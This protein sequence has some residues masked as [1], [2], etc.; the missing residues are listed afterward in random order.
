MGAM[1][2]PGGCY[3]SPQWGMGW[4]ARGPAVRI[5]QFTTMKFVRII[6]FGPI[7]GRIQ[8]SGCGLQILVENNTK[9]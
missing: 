6:R 4:L 9:S 1:L 5:N 3:A 2:R 7:S 8:A